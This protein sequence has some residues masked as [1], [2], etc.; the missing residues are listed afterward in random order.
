MVV[1]LRTPVCACEPIA[2]G[3]MLAIVALGALLPVSDLGFDSAN[4]EGRSG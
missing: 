4:Y 1:A 2:T 3:R